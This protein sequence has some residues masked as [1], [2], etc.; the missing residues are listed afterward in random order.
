MDLSLVYPFL[1]LITLNFLYFPITFHARV[2]AAK[3]GR[4]KMRQFKLMDI[5][6]EDEWVRKTTRHYSNL[7]EVPVLFYALILMALVLNLSSP[8]LSGL[9]WAYVILRVIQAIIHLG[10][11][12]VMHRLCVFS[13]GNLCLAIFLIIVCREVLT[14]GS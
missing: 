10:Y 14:R 11:N 4:I 5:G 13:A 2:T 8:L 12:N 1:S 6:V 3:A 9:A 7:F